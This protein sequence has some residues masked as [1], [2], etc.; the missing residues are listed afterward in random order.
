[1]GGAKITVIYPHPRDIEP[2]ERRYRE[3]HVP[4]MLKKLVGKS[5]LPARRRGAV[6]V[7]A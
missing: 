4:V 6:H 5:N 2:F 7:P 1:M 3:E